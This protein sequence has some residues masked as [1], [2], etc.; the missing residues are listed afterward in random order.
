MMELNNG[1]LPF[2]NDT[3]ISGEGKIDPKSLI[4][5]T[6]T[7]PQFLQTRQFFEL[8]HD[9]G[10]RLTIQLRPRID[11]G[12][13]F[14]DNHWMCY[15]RNYFQVTCGFALLTDFGIA[16]TGNVAIRL[17]TGLQPIQRFALTLTAK[18]TDGQGSSS[19]DL[20]QR[21][22]KREKGPQNTPPCIECHPLPDANLTIREAPD[23]C[24]VTYERLQFKAASIANSRRRTTNFHYLTVQLRAILS[25]GTQ[26]LI[27][28]IDSAPLV[29]RNRSPGFYTSLEV[30]VDDYS[31]VSPPDSG[32]SRSTIASA[33]RGDRVQ[34]PSHHMGNRLYPNSAHPYSSAQS[35]GHS[36]QYYDLD[37]KNMLEQSMKSASML[38]EGLVQ[39]N[40]SMLTP[41]GAYETPVSGNM[42]ALM[43]ANMYD[44]KQLGFDDSEDSP[45]SVTGTEPFY[46]ASAPMFGMGDDLTNMYG[47]FTQ[48]LP[49]MEGV[50]QEA[51]SPFM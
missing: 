40:Y 3:M 27:A 47:E 13:S 20:V 2:L 9:N 36:S 35:A 37:F 30:G 11:R 51:S 42:P 17:M 45:P 44:F 49:T 18:C 23:N 22:T 34:R 26:H 24:S 41:T 46:I 6:E 12:F 14:S 7:S 15:R 39:D 21:T 10:E 43:T 32:R 31:S 28:M 50:K 48:Q 1:Y 29:V 16:R 25:D 33:R 38:G 19:I 4:Q 5:S 8:M